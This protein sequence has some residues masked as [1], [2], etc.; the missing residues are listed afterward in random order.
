MSVE[1]NPKFIWYGNLVKQNDGYVDS[2]VTPYHIEV[3]REYLKDFLCVI[4][5]V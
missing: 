1:I 5:K 4:D 3:K 2:K